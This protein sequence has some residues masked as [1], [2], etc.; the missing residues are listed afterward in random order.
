[1]KELLVE[2]LKLINEVIHLFSKSGSAIKKT[3]MV[4]DAMHETMNGSTKVGSVLILCTHNSGKNLKTYT[5][6]YVSCLHEDYIPPFHS[7]KNSYQK[8]P[9]D[10]SYCEMAAKLIDTK[11]VAVNRSTLIDGSL[12]E[13]IYSTEKIASSRY[14]YLK[15]TKRY[16]FF[17]S[18]RT[19]DETKDLHEAETDL[20]MKICVG[21]IQQLLR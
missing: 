8:L 4:Y 14:F 15:E 17:V 20:A 13:G 7:V 2:F 18:F 9:L 19:A 10:K 16:F 21:K 5:P 12:L 1:M 3:A 6:M 11:D